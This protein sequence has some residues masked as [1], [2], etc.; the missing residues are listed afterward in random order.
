MTKTKTSKLVTRALEAAGVNSNI[1]ARRL[2]VSPSGLRK[3]GKGTRNPPRWVLIQLASL[4]RQ[5]AS[6]LQRVSRALDKL[7]RTQPKGTNGRKRR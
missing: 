7:A 6:T 4:L 5:Q 2:K 1:L 3:F